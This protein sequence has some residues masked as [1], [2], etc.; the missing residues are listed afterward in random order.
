MRTIIPLSSLGLAVALTGA[1]FASPVH[2][3]A[4]LAHMRHANEPTQ[5]HYW[6]KRCYDSC[7]RPYRLHDRLYR[8]DETRSRGTGDLQAP[9]DSP[10][11][12]RG[13]PEM[14]A[15]AVRSEPPVWP[16]PIVPQR[17]QSL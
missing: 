9:N 14:G 1:A 11:V 5:I 2:R 6:H 4:L 15:P 16:E 13:H 10:V 7:D 17:P 12:G 3:P 8:R